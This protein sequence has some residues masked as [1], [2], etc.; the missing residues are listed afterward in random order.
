MLA[1][2]G[3]KRGHLR[4]A[5]TPRAAGAIGRAELPSVG[6]RL[7]VPRRKNNSFEASEGEAI[8]LTHQCPSFPVGPNKHGSQRS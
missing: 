1:K 2:T 8:H 4:R 7:A 5:F 3:I 6:S